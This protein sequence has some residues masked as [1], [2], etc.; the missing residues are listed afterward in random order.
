MLQIA[1]FALVGTL[2]QGL[3]LGL[4]FE[5]TD[6]CVFRITVSKLPTSQPEADAQ[7]AKISEKT[8]DENDSGKIISVPRLGD[9]DRFI[10]YIP[11]SNDSVRVKY[12]CAGDACGALK[13]NTGTWS[14]RIGGGF[15]VVKS[16][17]QKT[18]FV[19]HFFAKNQNE[20]VSL[21]GNTYIGLF[22]KDLDGNVV[23]EDSQQI[24][25]GPQDGADSY[26]RSIASNSGIIRVSYETLVH[27]QTHIKNVS[28]VFEGNKLR[29]Q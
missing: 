29:R 3:A 8:P 6:E 28:F 20:S 22:S 9:L 21:N 7:P 19:A 13:G 17:L 4:T 12:G 23:H 11:N 5:K 16:D 14:V 25:G 10:V 1:S 24:G 18:W 26:V 15:S 27:G 2:V